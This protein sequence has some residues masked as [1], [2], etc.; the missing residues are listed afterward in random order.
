MFRLHAATVAAGFAAAGETNAPRDATEAVGRTIAA[1]FHQPEAFRLAAAPILVVTGLT[2]EA[3][4]VAGAGLIA[5]AGGAAAGLAGRIEAAVRAHAPEAIVSF[6][7]AG[8]LA[9]GLEPGDLVAGSAVLAGEDRVE[10]DVEWRGAIITALSGGSGEVKGG[11]VLV[12]GAEA[13]ITRADAKR[14]LYERTGAAIV[15]MESAAAARVAAAHGLPLAVV[16]AVS[17]SA[18]Q[19]LPPAV[20]N[21]M[22]PDGGMDLGGVLASLAR[23]LRQ[24]PA[25]IRTGREAERGFRA[26]DNARRLLG[27]RLGRPDLG[28]LLL[29]VS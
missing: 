4:I 5:V 25:L 24:L 21:G 28:Q 15:D 3:R 27:L 10:C 14:A 22:K 29:D 1:P 16:R 20:L 19:T 6:G 17:D 23:D 8:A 9:P 11:D 7:L 13:M 2:R 18:G 26:L 12:L